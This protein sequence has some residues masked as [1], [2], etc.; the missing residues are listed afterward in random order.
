MLQML[1]VVTELG[2]EICIAERGSI[3][4]KAVLNWHTML[5]CQTLECLDRIQRLVRIQRRLELCIHKSGGMICEN[6]SSNA[7]IADVLFAMRL[8]TSTWQR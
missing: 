5:V 2:L 7:S 4:R 3:V 6:G 8:E 1:V